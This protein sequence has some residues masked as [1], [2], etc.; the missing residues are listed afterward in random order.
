FRA[1]RRPVDPAAVDRLADVAMAVASQPDSTF[2]AGVA[3]GMVAVLASPRF[4]FREERALPLKPG[5]IYADVDEY[6]LASRLSYF[7]W[8]SMPDQELFDLAA[9]GELRANLRAQVRRLLADPRSQEFVRN[10]TGQWLQ[11]RDVENVPISDF[12]VFLREHP[13]PGVVEARNVF[14]RLRQIPDGQR[15]PEQDEAMR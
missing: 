6:A 10:F 15:T 9:A 11:A 5:E 12:S 4:L 7:F 2:E 13:N 3:Q 8:S 1:Y 14:M